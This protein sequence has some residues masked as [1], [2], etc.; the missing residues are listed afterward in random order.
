M[1]WVANMN[2]PLNDTYG[3]MNISQDAL[4]SWVHKAGRISSGVVWILQVFEG[5]ARVKRARV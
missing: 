3:I 4:I 1:V 5:N 2:N